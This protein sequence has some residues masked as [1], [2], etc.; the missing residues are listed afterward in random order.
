M[1][2]DWQKTLTKIQNAEPRV[3]FVWLTLGASFLLLLWAC[4]ARI[5]VIV[6]T[7]GR[8]VPAGKSQ[9]VQHLEGGIVRNLLVHEGQMVRAGQVLVELSDIQAR[10]SVDQ[11]QSK[12]SALKGREARLI[13]ESSGAGSINFP[14]DLAE[15]VRK[16]ESIAFEARRARVSDEIR[17]LRDQ[18]A[19]KRNEISEAEGRRKNLNAELDVA[20]QQYKVIDGLRRNGAASSLEVLDSQSKLQRLQSQIAETEAAIPRLKA[21]MSETESKVGEVWARYR[22]EASSELTQVRTELEK[23]TFELG[24]TKDRLDRNQVKAPVSGVINRMTITTIGGVVR[25]GEALM[26]ITPDDENVLI[27][28]RAKPN[29]RANLRI[30][31]P[32]RIRIGAYDYATFGTLEGRV[33]EVSADTLLDEREGRYYR[34]ILKAKNKQKGMETLPGMTATAD[35]VVGKRT[36][37]SFILSPLLKFKDTAFRDSK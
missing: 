15:E 30:D 4:F 5:D 28:A 26:E 22:A 24:S 19:Q 16:A 21:A 36:V 13:A 31:L 14:K 7:E 29:E 9:I 27:E 18:N 17:V 1:K 10:S 3:A 32:A 37:I 11:E 20:Q 33:T 34:V 12:S 23:S 2:F 25:P 8:V 6:R 35:V